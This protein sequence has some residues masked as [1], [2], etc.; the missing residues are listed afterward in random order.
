MLLALSSDFIVAVS[1]DEFANTTVRSVSSTILAH[2]W[3]VMGP[4]IWTSLVAVHG[5]L[6]CRNVDIHAWTQRYDERSVF[7]VYLTAVMGR[8][9]SSLWCFCSVS[10]LHTV[11]YK[12]TVRQYIIGQYWWLNPVDSAVKLIVVGSLLMLTDKTWGAGNVVETVCHAV[13]GHSRGC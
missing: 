9:C 4:N 6:R 11:H 5:G 10:I 12:L 7:S 13:T 1:V 2:R 3:R 8:C